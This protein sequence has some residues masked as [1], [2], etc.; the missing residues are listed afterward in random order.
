MH[1]ATAFVN[2][3]GGDFA[4]TR[5][6]GAL[7]VVV[8]GRLGLMRGV[9]AFA[10]IGLASNAIRDTGTIIVGPATWFLLNGFQ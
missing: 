10:D 3:G 2:D 4:S 1:V 9:P 6:I 8:T 7:L 5:I